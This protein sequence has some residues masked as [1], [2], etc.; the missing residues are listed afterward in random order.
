MKA[1][2]TAKA[3]PQL[4]VCVL[5]NTGTPLYAEIKRVSDTIIGVATQCVQSKHTMQPKIQY[6]ANVCLKMNVKLGGMNSFLDPPEIPF[7]TERPTII[8]GAD[9]TH[10]APGKNFF[11]SSVF[12]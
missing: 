1:S 5:P 3:Q 12:I 9:M 11:H 2:N 7:I 4:I 8:M 10:P 6:C